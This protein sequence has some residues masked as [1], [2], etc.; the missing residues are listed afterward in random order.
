VPSLYTGANRKTSAASSSTARFAGICLDFED[1]FLVMMAKSLLAKFVTF[2]GVS[3]SSFR[4]ALI[5]CDQK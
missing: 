1:V 4:M 5:N 2:R 3:T